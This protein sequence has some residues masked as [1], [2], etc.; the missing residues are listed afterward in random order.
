MSSSEVPTEAPKKKTGAFPEKI[1][2]VGKKPLMGYIVAALMQ[3]QRGGNKVIL[4]AR[5]RNISS[6]VDVAEI[7]KNKFLP[8]IVEVEKVEIGTERIGEGEKARD[9]SVIEIHLQNISS[10]VMNLNIYDVDNITHEY[11]V[12]LEKKLNLLEIIISSRKYHAVEEYP[13]EIQELLNIRK[14]LYSLPESTEKSN[15]LNK[16]TDLLYNYLSNGGILKREDLKEF[17]L[18]V[19]MDKDISVILPSLGYSE[20]I[21]K[22]MREI[23]D[24]D[25]NKLPSELRIKS[26]NEAILLYLLFDLARKSR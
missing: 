10:K 23:I 11:F 24:K 15:L 17:I 22:K 21:V 26:K 12:Q 19:P 14:I 1:V 7:L 4:K 20:E 8:N 2:Y 18:N 3:F 25:I 6:A 13:K 9:V 16:T 5:G